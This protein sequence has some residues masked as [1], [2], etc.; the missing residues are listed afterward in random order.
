MNPRYDF[1]LKELSLIGM[2]LD[3]VSQATEM[4]LEMGAEAPEGFVET[5]KSVISKFEQ[6][7]ELRCEH[8]NQFHELANSLLDVDTKSNEVIKNPDS[9]LN[10]YN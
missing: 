6:I 2:S 1:T 5:L 10:E 8:N 3:S 7:I 9:P 4:S